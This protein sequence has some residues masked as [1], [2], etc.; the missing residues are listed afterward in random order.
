MANW[1]D[2]I[3]AVARAVCAKTPADDGG[4]EEQLPTAADMLRHMVAV[5]FE[6]RVIDESGDYRW[7]R[8]RLG[9]QDVRL[10][11]SDA[12]PFGQP[13]GNHGDM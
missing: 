3:E 9:A 2:N 13:R 5:E 10:P 1:N 12:P 4:S 11:R 8:E 7:G 6:C